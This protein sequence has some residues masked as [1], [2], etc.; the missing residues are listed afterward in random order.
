V[1]DNIN[2]K[3]YTYWSIADNFEWNDAY[4]SRFGLVW[5]NYDTFNRELKQ[6]YYCFQSIIAGQGPAQLAN[7]CPLESTLN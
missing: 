6:S 5:I 4:N 3:L 7:N 2:I 1:L